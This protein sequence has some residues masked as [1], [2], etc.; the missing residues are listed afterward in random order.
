MR[1]IKTRLGTGLVLNLIVV[2]ALQWG[3]VSLTVRR[4]TEDY[5]ASRLQQDIEELLAA[6][7]FEPTGHPVLPTTTVMQESRKAF[8][9]YY[10]RIETS[11]GV[12]RSRSLWDEDLVLPEVTIGA[13]LR[14]KHD[15]PL[16]QPLLIVV[17]GF[18]KR[19][20]YVSIAVAED[21]T[22][23]EQEIMDFQLIYL[24]L[25]AGALVLNCVS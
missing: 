4:V 16:D 17:R 19:D 11:A 25:S 8:S 13:N 21:M 1:S 24:A 23:F 22:V 7:S 14:L 2:F 15:G 20:V 6:L 10:Y 18:S 3:L 9:G 5:V 12:L